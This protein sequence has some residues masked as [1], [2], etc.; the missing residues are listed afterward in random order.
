MNL[1]IFLRFCNPDDGLQV[2]LV[3]KAGSDG[4]ASLIGRLCSRHGRVPMMI[5][6][7]VLSPL[8]FDPGVHDEFLSLTSTGG[9][10]Q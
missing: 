1:D 7:P 8:R 5:S 2:Q 9:Y 3:I 10:E 4:F 6:W